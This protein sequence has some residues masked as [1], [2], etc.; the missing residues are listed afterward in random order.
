MKV[1][2]MQ[3][4]SLS[5]VGILLVAGLTASTVA[6]ARPDFGPC[7]DAGEAFGQCVADIAQALR[8]ANDGEDPA[9]TTRDIVDGCAGL[10]REQ[11]GACV[12]EAARGQ[13][14]RGDPPGAA[15]SAAARSLVDGCRE[16]QGREF[17]EC[18]RA[19]AHELGHGAGKKADDG[20]DADSG[21]PAQE[22]KP[23][24]TGGSEVSD[25]DD[26]A[27]GGSKPPH[28]AKPA[29]NGKPSASGS[30]GSGARKP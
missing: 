4:L 22:L 23:K 16:L 30:H 20:Q 26:G 14:E 1:D 2:H 29:H 3:Q 13:Q 6:A 24:R 17:G 28:A 25:A 5:I 12:S 18:V 15:V 19:G 9:E 27:E 7:A 21:T 10:S 8:G 11:F